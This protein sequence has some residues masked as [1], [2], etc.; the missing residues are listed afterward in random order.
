[1]KNFTDGIKAVIFDFDGTLYNPNGFKKRL[2]LSTLWS[3]PL[4]L[5]DRK[6]RRLNKGRDFGSEEKFHNE[7]YSFIASHSFVAKKTA[8]LWKSRVYMA[9]MSKILRKKYSAQKDVQKLFDYLRDKRIPVAVFS[10]YNCVRERMKDI[11]LENLSGVSIYDSET[12]GALKPCSRGFLKISMDMGVEPSSILVVGDRNDTD[13][14][15][16]RKT[17]MKFVQVKTRKNQIMPEGF[18]HTF[19]AWN[20]FLEVALKGF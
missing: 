11:G 4:V 15:G 16:A 7:Y 6:F 18:D 20:D 17:G 19:V 14:E 8:A 13:G 2:V 9:A 10:D 12:F 3:M 1:M 5:A